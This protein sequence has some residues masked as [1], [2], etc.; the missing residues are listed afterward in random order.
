MKV[1]Q[2]S[3]KGKDGADSAQHMLHCMSQYNNGTLRTKGGAHAAWARTSSR[4]STEWEK[5]SEQSGRR[6]NRKWD[7][8]RPCVRSLDY[9]KRTIDR[10]GEQKESMRSEE[11]HRV[12][13]KHET[14]DVTCHRR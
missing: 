8:P 9:Q 3:I 5:G 10:K 4:S 2:G 12:E 1:K 6:V 7:G 14:G 13:G 11:K